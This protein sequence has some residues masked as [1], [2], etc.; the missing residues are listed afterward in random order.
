[1]SS[2]SASTG[3]PAAPGPGPTFGHAAFGS[4]PLAK[5]TA[6][7]VQRSG[8]GMA[9]DTTS[10][11]LSLLTVCTYV[12][13]TYQAAG[14]PTYAA[15]RALDLAC[16]LLFAVEWAFW[17]WLAHDRLRSA[18][19]L[20]SA[21][22]VL[23]VVPMI[24]SYFTPANSL[25][26]IERMLRLLRILRVFRIFRLGKRIKSEIHSRLLTLAFTLL[27]ILVAAAGF[28]YEVETNYSDRYPELTFAQSLYWSA[29]TVTTIGY[30]DLSPSILASQMAL[31][32]MLVLTFTLLPFQSSALIA[33]LG[34]S[35]PHQRACYSQSKRGRHVVVTGHLDCAVVERLVGELYAADYGFQDFN[36]VLLGRA[37]PGDALQRLLKTHAQAHRLTYI[38]GCLLRHQDLARAQV[39]L[40]DALL[41][42]CDKRP[43]DAAAE[44]AR[45]TAVLVAAAHLAQRAARRA[46]AAA[47]AP[48]RARRL[49]EWLRPRAPGG[50]GGAGP[51]RVFIQVLLQE[52]RD[53]ISE[54]VQQMCLAGAPGAAPLHEK[55]GP[56]WEEGGGKPAAAAAAEGQGAAGGSD[57]GGSDGVPLAEVQLVRSGSCGGGGGA[58]GDAG[59]AGWG[60]GLPSAVF[61]RLFA[62]RLSVQCVS[63]AKYSLL[64]HSLGCPGL[65]AVVA[66]LVRGVD[67]GDILP[68]ETLTMRRPAPPLN[69][70]LQFE[71]LPGWLQEYLEGSANEIYEAAALPPHLGGRTFDE[72]RARAAPRRAREGAPLARYI[73]DR[74]GAVLVA[75]AP[76]PGAQGVAAFSGGGSGGGGWRGGLRL[77]P[78]GEVVPAGARAFIIALDLRA[79]VDLSEAPPSDYEEWAAEKAER[80]APGSPGGGG[81]AAVAPPLRGGWAGRG[82]TD[83]GGGGAG[84]ASGV[85]RHRMGYAGQQAR[86]PTPAGATPRQSRSPLPTPGSSSRSLPVQQP[87]QEQQQQQEEQQHQRQQQQQTGIDDPGTGHARSLLPATLSPA[88][89]A[90]GPGASLYDAALMLQASSLGAAAA[91]AP[92]AAPPGGG[93]GR[94]A[95]SLS[96]ASRGGHALASAMQERQY[97]VRPR[98]GGGAEDPNSAAADG[99]GGGGAAAIVRESVDF[100]GHTLVCGASTPPEALLALLAPLRSAALLG[101]ALPPVVI[102]DGPRPAGPLWGEVARLE[103]VFFVEG[104]AGRAEALRRANAERAARAVVLGPWAGG[105]GGG[106]GEGEDGGEGAALSDAEVVGVVRRLKALNR[107]GRGRRAAMEVVCELCLPQ[108]VIHL[109]ALGALLDHG[110]AWG[111]GPGGGGGGG[112]PAAPAHMDG[113]ALLGGFMDGVLCQSFYN[114]GTDRILSALLS[115]WHAVPA[116]GAAPVQLP[117]P[118]GCATYGE[119]FHHLLSRRGAL[120]LALVRAAR[121][122]GRRLRYVYTAPLRDTALRPGDAVIAL[123]R[124]G[125]GRPRLPPDALCCAAGPWAAGGGGGARGAAE[126][127]G[128][129][130]AGGAAQDGGGGGGG[131]VCGGPI[132]GA[133][134]RRAAARL[135][136]D[137]GGALGGAGGGCDP[138]GSP[139][140][141][142]PPPTDGG[143]GAAAA[144]GASPGGWQRARAAL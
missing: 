65:V 138:R 6:I 106:G 90:S 24:V 99:G 107:R 108:D 23:T 33:A 102:L 28:F 53:Q 67:E 126:G 4:V 122:Q 79:S 88:R 52:S 30:G 78:I 56:L 51:P 105:G 12:A 44:D 74:H 57:G 41:I 9:I 85:S 58:A 71:A 69:Y 133:A 114:S 21:V 132:E 2:S 112:A 36:M 47:A 113:S 15:L 101:A 14:S 22:D 111:D 35:S 20:Q 1:M 93:P 100:A 143:G 115:Q 134:G 38:Q 8:A 109:D 91:A 59:G 60:A 77:A 140:R 76:G 16:S 83:G 5:R 104:S 98:G 125:P 96:R 127:A 130:V 103:G 89:A 25:D 123:Y 116:G 119:A 7:W 86:S 66:N 72:A 42:M 137:E 48:R 139:A 10:A 29:V 97:H 128:G 70:F 94:L 92:G 18:T 32:L 55:P 124:L 40:A 26:I 110:G 81:A 135:S 39:H 11:L 61:W 54:I 129:D 63:E 31:F 80:G 136:W 73:F 142:A 62:E 3:V 34:A 43:A 95:P 120:P 75:V 117:V 49:A 121:C 64:G 68:S 84:V 144:A 45:N 17:L 46:A 87:P 27:A 82:S 37:A 13:Q 50:G 118:P 131:G 141:G 19:S